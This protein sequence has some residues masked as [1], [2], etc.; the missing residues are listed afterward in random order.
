MQVNQPIYIA[1]L[2]CS[3]LLSLTYLMPVTYLAFF[4][5]N[6]KGE[7]KTYGEANKF[8]LIP[9]CVT[10]ALS[11]ILGIMPNFGPHLYDL[12]S[13]AAQSITQGWIGGGW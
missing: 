10:A 4:K 5:E 2:I 6:E 1:V 7:F 8:M 12:A 3:A 11:V 13:M 9:I